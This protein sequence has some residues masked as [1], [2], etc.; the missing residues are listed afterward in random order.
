MTQRI[1]AGLVAGMFCL[2]APAIELADYIVVDLSHT[3]GSDTLYWP[4]SPSKFE[5]T[6]LAYGESEAGFFYSA[7]SLCTPEHGGT[8]LDAPMHFAAGGYPTDKV[9]LERLIGDAVVID[10]SDK[11]SAD[12]DY[13]L[14]AADVREF[15]RTHGRIRPGTIVLLRTGWSRF[16]PDAK[17]YLG[18]DTPGDASRLSF[19]SYGEDAARLLVEERKVAVLGVDTASADFGKSQDFIVHRIAAAGNVSNLENLTNLDRLPATGA[20][21]FALPMNIQGGSGGPVRVVA[22]LPKE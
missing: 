3:Y 4:T 15:E 10:I 21:V 13:L 9:P 14:S 11:A 8:H 1:V 7:Y 18:D 16:W 22:L 17:S 19:P 5:M 12:R 6:E 2:P 20:V